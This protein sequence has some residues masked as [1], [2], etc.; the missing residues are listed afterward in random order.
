MNDTNFTYE[1]IPADFDNVLNFDT[2]SSFKLT[3]VNIRSLMRNFE[4]L[5]LMYEDC[6]K[7]KFDIIGLSEVLFQDHEMYKRPFLLS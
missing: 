5:K 1:L 7:T 2:S 3:H 6:I 4:S